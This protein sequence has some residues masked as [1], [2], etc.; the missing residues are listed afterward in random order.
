MTNPRKPLKLNVGFIVNNE[1]GYSRDFPFD[2]ETIRVAE[3][4]ELRDFVGTARFSRT[5]QGLLLTGQFRAELDLQCARC[6]RDF[7]QTVQWDITELF[8]FNEKS[9]TDSELLVPE[10]AQIDIA[11]FVR[12]YALT[13]IPINPVCKP[14]CK[15][16][17]PTCGQDLNQKDCGHRADQNDSPFAS[18]KDLFNN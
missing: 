4:L 10:D 1:V 2:Y 17:C 5:A 7:A 9:L 6:L 15:G 18:L 12:D 3:D 11:P 13:E 16:L 8:A 14:D